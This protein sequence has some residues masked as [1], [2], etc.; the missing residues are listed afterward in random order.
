VNRILRVAQREYIEAVKTKTFIVSVLMTPV[1]IGIII[2]FTGRLSRDALGPRPPR[3]V[4]VT[5]LT[6]RLGDYL[7][8]SFDRYNEAHSQRRIV[9]ELLPPEPDVDGLLARAK[10][11]VRE[12]EW[13]AYA[14]MEKGVVDGDGKVRLYTHSKRAADIDIGGT[15]ERRLTGAVVDM[16]CALRDLSPALLAEIRQVPIE[17]LAADVGPTSQDTRMRQ[18]DQVVRMMIP[19]FFMFLMFMGIFGTGQQM[20]SSVIEEKSSRVIE[21]LLSALT[22][23]QFMAGKIAGLAAIGLTVIAIWSVPAVVVLGLQ[24]INLDMGVGLPICFVIYYVLGFLL[25]SSVL[26]ALGSICN[27]IKEAQSLMMPM[28]L[29][30]VLPMVAWF[31]IA[32]NPD[33]A[34]ARILSY[35]PPITPMVMIL[36]ISASPQI[37]VVEVVATILLLAATV[38]AAVWMAAKVF[39]TGV[40]MY[41]KRPALREVLRWLGEK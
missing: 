10:Q 20:L 25:F 24:G 1:L 12:G 40:F 8:A 4:A 19:F 7:K 6:G 15:I 27:T 22:P 31:N 9:L 38:P 14:V 29:I 36:R 28:S 11:R 23:F 26:A 39:R 37:A 32:Q 18:I 21:M 17:Q 5:D 30:L 2:F 13:H 3:T 33:A 16:R 41:G 34:F 35:V